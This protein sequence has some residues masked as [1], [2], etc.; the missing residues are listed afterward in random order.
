MGS[1]DQVIDYPLLTAV[2]APA[3]ERIRRDRAQAPGSIQPAFDHL[4]DNL[5]ASALKS[6]SLLEVSGVVRSRFAERFQ[7]VTGMQPRAY[8]ESLRI[9]IACRLLQHPRIPILSIGTCLGWD[10]GASFTEVFRRV[11]GT[12]PTA[13][14]RLASAYSEEADGA[15]PSASSTVTRRN[16]RGRP[17]IEQWVDAA[18][19]SASAEELLRLI[20]YLD[21]ELTRLRGRPTVTRGGG[22][23]DRAIARSVWRSA[24]T[25]DDIRRKK[26][27]ASAGVI[28][29]EV[30]E[31]LF[32]K[33]RTAGRQDRQCG[34]SVARL[35]LATIDQ[36]PADALPVCAL[37]APSP[38]A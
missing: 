5:C 28:V 1:S 26:L 9:E 13:F 27:L 16:K 4:L 36:I 18:K 30:F 37:C 10:R 12:T 21:R 35:V 6:K 17:G 23:N 2:M 25:L 32:E 3:L 33:S 8:I 11:M 22:A 34:V 31:L 7:Q 29:P 20:D 14:R 24:S 19:G 38:A 15:P